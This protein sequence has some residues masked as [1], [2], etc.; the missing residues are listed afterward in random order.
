MGT[1]FMGLQIIGICAIFFALAL[2][3][4]GDGS[5]EQKMMEYFLVGALI[6][7]IGYLL[8]LTSPTME[9]A[10]VAVKMQ[11]LGTMTI[12]ICY[13]YFIY[14]YCFEEAPLGLLKLL[15]IIDGGLLLLILTCD[16]HGIFY[17]QVGWQTTA[18][19]HSY[20]YLEYG[21]GFAVFIVCAT[22]I[23]YAMSLRVL[24]RACARKGEDAVDRKYGLIL[25]LSL[26]P[27]IALYTYVTKVTQPYD[28]TPAVLGLVLSSVVILVWSRKV[29]DFG[30]LAS[31]TLLNSMSDGVIALDEKGRVVNYNP[32]AAGI[33]TELNSHAIGR[34]VA[35][36][37]DFPD[38]ALGEDGQNEFF[39]KE[40]F[41]QSHVEQ[42][43]DRF[44]VVKGYVVVILDMTEMRNH[45]EE[46]K[47]IRMQAEQAN[48]AKSEFLANMSHEIRT[49]MNAIVGLSDIIME[50]SKGRKVYSYACDI[51]SA[52]RNLLAL[53]N[54]ILDL[55]KVEAGKM[56]LV[57]ADYHIKNVTDEVINM[58][59]GAASK[60]GILLKCEYD[61]SIP[62]KY[63]GD[64]GR[65]RQ[66]FI[67]LLNNGLKFTREGYVKLSVGG[68][69]GED[70]DTE[71]LHIEVRDT[72]CGIKEEDLGKIFENFSQVDAKR[73]RAVEGTGLGLSITRHLVELMKGTIRVE[74]V[75]GEGTVFI[76]DIPQ[77]IVDRR[78]LTE[79]PKEIIREEDEIQIFTAEDCRVLVVDDNLVNR[80]VARGFL[81]PYR[82]IIDEADSG[83]KSIECVRQTKY[84]I[85]FMDHMMPE[86]DGI[87]AVQLIRSECGENGTLPVIIA[88]T[89]NAMEG[90]REMFL[91]NGFQDFITKPLDKKALNEALQKWIPEERRRVPDT[92]EQSVEKMRKT[93]PKEV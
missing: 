18:G 53:I 21:P 59:D 17:R 11:H 50:E 62:C 51:K 79:V 87:E 37:E 39:L 32:A 9:A 30:S 33:F 6:L 84:D 1:A 35:E 60:R 65:M 8:E 63:Y 89:A 64:E 90:V 44:G 31:G 38:I 45:L 48:E 55:S 78:S 72:G 26:L 66:I 93:K 3:L 67:N 61:M 7:N 24:I 81:R 73:N 76:L 75:Y 34:N 77:R 10:M 29:Y 23:P 40:R 49:P 42:I 54:D 80:K 56:E 74:S 69:P 15:G 46:I 36:I 14:I 12:P 92:W 86:M 47:R 52:S 85:I 28:F 43:A 71:V 4:S 82:F 19:G 41:Y 88:L 25:G 83:P 57:N 5:R 91:Q 13:S 58:M 70:A 22:L 16:Y 2:L 20:L 27:I 68:R